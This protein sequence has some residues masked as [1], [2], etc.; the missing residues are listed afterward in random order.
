MCLAFSAAPEWFWTG[1]IHRSCLFL[2]DFPRKLLTKCDS[3]VYI[4]QMF[5]IELHFPST[6]HRFLGMCHTFS[7]APDMFSTSLIHRTTVL[8][9][10]IE[11]KLFAECDIL[12]K[13][14]RG[15]VFLSIRSCLLP[16]LC[17]YLLSHR[18]CKTLTMVSAA[19]F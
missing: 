3:K 13:E 2:P 17:I 5:Q 16:R 18:T 4:H 9:L 6:W 7:T 10:D 12:Q 11:R 19:L 1:F 15:Q 14:S 8:L